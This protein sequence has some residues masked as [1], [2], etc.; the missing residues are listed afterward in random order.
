MSVSVKCNPAICFLSYLE[1][2]PLGKYY[3]CKFFAN[4]D[5]VSTFGRNHIIL[6]P[7]IISIQQSKNVDCLQMSGLLK[8]FPPRLKRGRK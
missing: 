5:A 2:Q 1:T 6:R 4:V 8:T 3:L 7:E